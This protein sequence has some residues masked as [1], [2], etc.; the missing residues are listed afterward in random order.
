MEHQLDTVEP[1]LNRADLRK[2]F[3]EIYANPVSAK[4]LLKKEKVTGGILL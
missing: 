3:L 2:H 1:E 4:E